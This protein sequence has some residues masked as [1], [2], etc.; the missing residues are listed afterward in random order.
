MST[1]FEATKKGGKIKETGEQC[2]PGVLGTE[3]QWNSWVRN[4]P[5]C[6]LHP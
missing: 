4:L 3:E 1:L 6:H 2:Q 5:V